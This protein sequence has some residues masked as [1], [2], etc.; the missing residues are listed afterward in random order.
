MFNVIVPLAGFGSRFLREGY[1]RPKPFIRAAGKEII[2]WLLENLLFESSDHLVFV[3]NR[4]PELGMSPENFFIIVEDFFS[5]KSSPPSVTYAALDKP[6]LGAAETVLRGIEVLPEERMSL[7][8]VLLDGDTFYSYDILSEYRQYLKQHDTNLSSRGG[9]LFVFDDD[10]PNESPYS[11]VRLREASGKYLQITNIA[12]KDKTGM[13]PFACSGCYCFNSSKYL[14]QSIT[15]ALSSFREVPGSQGK[16]LYTSNIVS[17][18]LR[19]GGVFDGFRLDAG[20]FTVLGTPAQLRAFVEQVKIEHKRFCFDLDN[21]LV[22]APRVA[23][24]YNTCGPIKAMID[25]V[26]RLHDEGH[27]I[28]IHTARRMRT[29]SGNLG[30]VISDIGDVT[31]KQLKNFGIPFDELLFGKPHADFYVDDK[32]VVALVDSL[33][34]ETGFPC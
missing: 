34:K 16:E 15:G 23:G 29:H 8:S 9:L 27:Y 33:S 18:Q 32:A 6:T 19:E 1:V 30:A 20:A 17:S 25:H 4:N 31:I 5:R 24:D 2:I 21:T 14:K 7:P 22:T 26:R 11:Y 3:F 13:D 12:E 10:K 28:I